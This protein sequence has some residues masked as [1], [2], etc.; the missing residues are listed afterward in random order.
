M[1]ACP[2]V[3]AVFFWF[4]KKPTTVGVS[5]LQGMNMGLDCY[6]IKPG[7]SKSQPLDFHPPLCIEDDYDHKDR[8]EGWAVF[9]GARGFEYAI[10]DITG[11]SLRARLTTGTVLQIA[12]QL[13]A[14]AAQLEAVAATGFPVPRS[15][16]RRLDGSPVPGHSWEDFDGEVYRDIARMFRAYGGAGYE[17]SGSW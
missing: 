16:F 7:E 10:R 11:V 8:R 3:T 1:S 9:A 6:W 13:D 2:S 4:S 17:L 5:K 15:R 14:F 12:E